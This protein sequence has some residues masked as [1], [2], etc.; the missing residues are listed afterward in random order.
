MEK[1]YISNHHNNLLCVSI[2]LTN[3][4]LTYKREITVR[5]KSMLMA[6][7]DGV[8]SDPGSSQRKGGEDG[9]MRWERRAVGVGTHWHFTAG[10]RSTGERTH[11]NT[12]LM[13]TLLLKGTHRCCRRRGDHSGA[14]AL[15][16]GEQHRGCSSLAHVNLKCAFSYR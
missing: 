2:T 3:I 5:T 12:A 7:T 13:G 15:A 10:K 4:Y 16:L 1:K 9:G 8:Q 6:V 14:A 11:S